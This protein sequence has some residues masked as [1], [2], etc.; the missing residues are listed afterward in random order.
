MIVALGIPPVVVNM[1][2]A[3][4]LE[5]FFHDALYPKNLFRGEALPEEWPANLGE[6]QTF[7][8]T[9]LITPES[10]PLTPGVDPTPKTYSLEQWE[11]TA[12]QWGA[13]LDTHMPTS[14]IAL[15]PL[16]LRNTQ[17]LGLQAAM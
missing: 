11:V 3:R 15:A 1:I 9:G 13:T 4:T 2:Q 12:A 10:A 16:F 6:N 5:R 7:S 14:T 8:R 17:Q